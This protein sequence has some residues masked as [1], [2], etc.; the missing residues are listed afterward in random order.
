M[1]PGRF[2]SI[3][4][5]QLK[6]SQQDFW[7]T[8]RTGDPAPRPSTPLEEPVRHDGWVVDALIHQIGLGEADIEK[9]SPDEAK[10]VVFDHWSKTR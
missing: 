7:E 4:R 8:L 2:L 5:A 1:S 3:L 6:V 10:Q 9:L